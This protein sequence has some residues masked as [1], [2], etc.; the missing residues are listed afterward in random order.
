MKIVLEA[1]W[2]GE[3]E[4]RAR[5]LPDKFSA[6]MVAWSGGVERERE[7][8]RESPPSLPL[9]G[10]SMQNGGGS[11]SSSL[12]RWK[13]LA[14]DIGRGREDKGCMHGFQMTDLCTLLIS[15]MNL[16]SIQPRKGSDLQW[17]VC[18]CYKV[19]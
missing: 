9:G 4:G 2:Q 7:E 10:N 18:N 16:R 12:G 14:A 11:C 6:E 19:R 3:K 17:S 15:D 5:E 13:Q 8:G 1:N